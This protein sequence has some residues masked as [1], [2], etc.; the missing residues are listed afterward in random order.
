MSEYPQ[1]TET[2]KEQFI[3]A[4]TE[5]EYAEYHLP[6]GDILVTDWESDGTYHPYVVPVESPNDSDDAAATIS[7]SIAT[8]FDVGVNA[9]EWD[10]N[11]EVY[12]PY[13]ERPDGQKPK[14]PQ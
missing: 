13:M 8:V 9:I 10:A 3:N 2:T 1:T 11:N 6:C 12:V 5:D 7:Q 14:C 4:V